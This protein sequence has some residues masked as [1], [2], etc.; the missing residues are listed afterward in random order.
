M[1]QTNTDHLDTSTLD[2]HPEDRKLGH[3]FVNQHTQG[4][5]PHI[6]ANSLAICLGI[7]SKNQ[8]WDTKE[9]IVTSFP[10]FRTLVS[11]FCKTASNGYAYSFYLAY[12]SVDQYFSDKKLLNMFRN[13]FYESVNNKCPTAS[14]YSIHFVEC[15]HQKQP[16]KAQNDAC[17]AAYMDNNE[18][19]YRL[20]DD[21]KM[22][23]PNW[24]EKFI[25]TLKSYDPPFVGVVGPAHRGGNLEVLTHEC[26]HYTHI[27]IHGVHYPRVMIDWYADEWITIIYRPT[28][29]TKLENVVL[30]HTMELG[31]RYK[32]R[33]KPREFLLK[34]LKTGTDVVNK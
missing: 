5:H 20:N 4:K 16:A 15:S 32:V 30:D 2:L 21:S 13:N 18:F 17:M 26:I 24:T 34:A 12:D 14:N 31:T 11:G 1:C 19:F 6:I 33:L 9:E 28:H 27:H 7:T 8:K 10:F 3:T 22:I 29:S 23:T 25:E